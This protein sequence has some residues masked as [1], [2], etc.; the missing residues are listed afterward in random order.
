MGHE[1]MQVF[2][3][4]YTNAFSQS[5]KKNSIDSAILGSIIGGEKATAESL[6]EK[7]AEIPFNFEKRRS[8][9]I[10]RT[11]DGRLLL[12]CKG[13][14][15]EVLSLCTRI[16][17]GRESS[18]M[19]P[20]ARTQLMQRAAA[21]NGDGYRV[22]VVATKEIGQNDLEDKDFLGDLESDMTFEGLLTFLDPPKD[23]AAASI[24]R[25]QALGV[26]VKVLTG[27]N[28]GVAL[29]VC[30]TLNL[31]TELD[32]GGVQ[33]ITGPDLAMLQPDEIKDV[34]KT[35]KVFA[36]LTPSQKAQVVTS[37]QNGGEN[38]GMLGDGVNDC[39]AL[40]FADVGISVDTG[41]AVAKSCADGTSRSQGT[42]SHSDVASSHSH[43]E[44]AW[45]HCRL[46]HCWSTY[47]RKHDQIHQDGRFLQFWQR[48]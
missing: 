27:D 8:S 25:L 5:G 7:V 46:C 47:S 45:Y 17:P 41:A 48:L 10:I 23:D 15:E 22:I 32:E 24:A 33:A 2:K 39:V 19:N 29:K 11:V 1:D 3:F 28:L 44:A 4:A 42:Y 37:L 36:K 35:C 30:R 31:V 40:R 38:V 20:E 16:R 12:I 34:V 21:F 6:G 18:S 43:S 9:C 26:D 14:F 13:A